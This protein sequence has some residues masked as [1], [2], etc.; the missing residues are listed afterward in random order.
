[1]LDKI[2]TMGNMGI[3]N[4]LTG[5]KHKVLAIMLALTVSVYAAIPENAA[6][7]DAKNG[8]DCTGLIAANYLHFA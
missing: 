5:G 3:T 2:G 1:M 7:S 8:V 6:N 4:F